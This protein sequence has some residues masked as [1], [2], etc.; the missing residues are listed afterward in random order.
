MFFYN[1][2]AAFNIL[3]IPITKRDALLDLVRFLQFKKLEKHTWR[4]VTFGKV[5]DLSLEPY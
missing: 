1:I 4:N 2:N 5:A 3:I